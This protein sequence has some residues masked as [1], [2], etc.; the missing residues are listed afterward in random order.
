[1]DI[2]HKYDRKILSQN[3]E[4]AKIRKEKRLDNRLEARVSKIEDDTTEMKMDIKVTSVSTHFLFPSVLH[5]LTQFLKKNR[6]CN[7]Y[8]NKS[9]SYCKV[10]LLRQH[11]HKVSR[12]WLH[13]RKFGY[14]CLHL[15]KFG[16]ANVASVALSNVGFD[17]LQFNKKYQLQESPQIL[18]KKS[19]PGGPLHFSHA[20]AR[21]NAEAHTGIKVKME[22]NTQQ[23][24]NPSTQHQ[25]DASTHI[26][27]RKPIVDNDY[28]V[29]P[30]D[31]EAG[32][33]VVMSYDHAKV[34]QIGDHVLT[35]KQLRPNFTDGFI[36]DEIN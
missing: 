9:Y 8:N 36:V 28:K 30:I 25:G 11:M 5:C 22:K 2:D 12:L 15:H 20:L 33:F 26:T 6:K 10:L 23:Q 27:P 18:V 4:L 29:S 1:M 24:N 32:C 3:E 31:T 14:L 7:R 13:L 21:I 35:A 17:I 19:A 16:Y 34:V